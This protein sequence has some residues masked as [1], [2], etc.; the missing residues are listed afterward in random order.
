MKHIKTPWNRLA[1]VTRGKIVR[2]V[3]RRGTY[4]IYSP[5]QLFTGFSWDCLSLAGKLLR[6]DPERI[7][8][9]GMGGGTVVRQCRHL[10]KRARIDGVEIDPEVIQAARLHFHLPKTNV[11]VICQ[12][13]AEFIRRAAGRYD[14][15]L[16][17]VWIDRGVSKLLF[18]QADYAPQILR[19]MNP[20]GIFAI[21]V[22][23]APD[24]SCQIAD[25]IKLLRAL[26]PWIGLLR[27]HSGPTCVLVAGANSGVAHISSSWLK[28]YS[29]TLESR[30]P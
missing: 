16:D 5:S 29:I 21:N 3:S 1:V 26:F 15:V 24:R 23:C 14:L 12:D 30:Y 4:S 28:T 10:Y 17:D 25:T 11:R 8:L 13:A 18:S 20:E 22:W 6:H 9:L 27:P 2:L 7:L 19:V